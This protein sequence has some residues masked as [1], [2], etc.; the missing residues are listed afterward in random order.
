MTI[1]RHITYLQQ[2]SEKLTASADSIAQKAFEKNPW[3]VPKFVEFSIHAIANDMLQP[4][5]LKLWLAPYS[6][7]ESSKTIGLIA[8]GNIP[9]AG[10]HDFLCAYLLGCRMKIKLSSKDDALLPEIIRLLSDIDRELSGKVEIVDTLKDFDAVIATGSDNT[11]RYFEY[12]FRSYPRIL[13][14]NRNSVGII[15]GNESDSELESLADDICLYFG[16]GCRN[17][18]K[19]YIPEGYDV[20][21]LFPGLKKYEW[22]YEHH[23]YRN[24]YDYQRTILLMNKTPHFA[25]DFIMMTESS[26]IPSPISVLHYEYY[27]NAETLQNLVSKQNEKIQCVVSSIPEKWQMRSSVYFGQSQHPKL[28]EYADGIDTISFLQSLNDTT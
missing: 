12:Y 5:K 16:F 24:N 10:F 13:R 7:H 18:S 2:L 20:R 1:E 11:N 8:A 27:G 22:M 15:S 17:V 3:F 28:W 25:N 21:L 26:Q 14:R 4:E 6:L 9:L 19:V 23:K